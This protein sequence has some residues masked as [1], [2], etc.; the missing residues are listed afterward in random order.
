MQRDGSP[1]L[2]KRAESLLRRQAAT[3]NTFG[4]TSALT[5]LT[6]AS[7]NCQIFHHLM[8]TV[9]HSHAAKM[10]ALVRRWCADH[11]LPYYALGSFSEAVRSFVRCAMLMRDAPPHCA[12]DTRPHCQKPPSTLRLLTARTSAAGLIARN[13]H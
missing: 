13:L 4:A 5:H 8:P 7:V 2:C 3:S 10:E 12:E 11:G 6:C 1:F 9:S